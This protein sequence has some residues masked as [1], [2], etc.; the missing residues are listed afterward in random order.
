MGKAISMPS[1]ALDGRLRQ[2]MSTKGRLQSLTDINVRTVVQ[3]Y[4]NQ[5]H[6]QIQVS[7]PSQLLAPAAWP[8]VLEWQTVFAQSKPKDLACMV[9]TIWE[10]YRS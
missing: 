4:L 10:A 1:G 8:V 5:G 2:I 3:S 7:S 9:S 6:R